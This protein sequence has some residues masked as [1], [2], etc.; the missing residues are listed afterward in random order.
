MG[1]LDWDRQAFP[2]PEGL[3]SWLGKKGIKLIAISE[4]FF[5]TAS[6]HYT[7]FKKLG[8]LGTGIDGSP[9]TWHDWWC[10]GDSECSVLNPLDDDAPRE[11]GKIY[12]HMFDTGIDGFW[13]DLGEPESV[14]SSVL[15]G[16]IPEPVF[17]NYF[18]YYWTKAIHSGVASGR[19]DY[20]QFILSRSAYT[21][22]SAYNVSTWPGD[23]SVSFQSLAK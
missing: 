6:S 18:N 3:D 23:V 19:P 8:M 5:T 14:P 7:D 13:T 22:S 4:P 9:L 20:R 10:F 1:D 15:F 17:H 21:G 2:D 16:G 11:L 12:T